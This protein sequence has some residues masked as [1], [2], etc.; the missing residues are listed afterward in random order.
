MKNDID[1]DRKKGK[2]KNIAKNL[3]G[4]KTIPNK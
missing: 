3:F 1:D 4:D 2:E